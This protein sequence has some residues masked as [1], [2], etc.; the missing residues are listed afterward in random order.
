MDE[1]HATLE[2]LCVLELFGYTWYMI[3]ADDALA[4]LI[5]SDILFKLYRCHWQL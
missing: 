3:R 4:Q 1:T 5:Q 2:S